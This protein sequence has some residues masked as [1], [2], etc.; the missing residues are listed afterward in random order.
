MAGIQEREAIRAGGV[1][2]KV[3][4]APVSSFLRVTVALG[5]AAPLGSV[6]VP[7]TP[8]VVSDY[9]NAASGGLNRKA[10]AAINTSR[11]VKA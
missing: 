11:R 10:M 7:T 6:T 9:P 3:C 4:V 5:T 8:P 2:V 1:L